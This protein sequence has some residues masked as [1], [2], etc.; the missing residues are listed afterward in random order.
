[1]CWAPLTPSYAI[2]PL[3]GTHRHLEHFR[4]FSFSLLSSLGTWI[5]LTTNDDAV[6]LAA[7]SSRSHRQKRDKRR[8]VKSPSLHYK[9]HGNM[10]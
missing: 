6:C 7:D 2:V 9:I 4:I 3:L 10:K 1:M 8:A 5:C